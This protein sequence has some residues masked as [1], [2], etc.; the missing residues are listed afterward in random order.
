MSI[1][2]LTFS[3]VMTMK[4]RLVIVAAIATL[5]PL[6]AAAHTKLTETAPA[7]GSV[8]KVAPDQIMLM[9]SE[10]ANLTKLTIQKAGDKAVQKL[11]P[12][13]KDAAAHFMIAAPKLGPGS[14]TLSYR[15]LS[16][17]NHVASGTVT[18]TIATDAKGT[19]P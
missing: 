15:A 3:E 7:N 11:G 19:K 1:V 9:F 18:F 4:R 13:P 16:D 2:L 5:F 14:Y 10:A 8:V 6:L 17:D 12:L